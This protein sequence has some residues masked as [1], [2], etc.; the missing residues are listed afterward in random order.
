MQTATKSRTN[1]NFAS[2]TAKVADSRPSVGAVWHRL[3]PGN[4]DSKKESFYFAVA[5][6]SHPISSHFKRRQPEVPVQSNSNQNKKVSIRL[7]RLSR[8]DSTL[9]LIRTYPR[10]IAA[11]RAKIKNRSLGLPRRYGH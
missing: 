1:I 5:G 2:K 9:P 8:F 3:V 10:L 7:S 11:I 4:I 6:Q